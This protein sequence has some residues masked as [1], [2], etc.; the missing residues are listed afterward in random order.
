[1]LRRRGKIK[2]EY[3]HLANKVTKDMETLIHYLMYD[4]KL[5]PE[6]IIGTITS[7]TVLLVSQENTKKRMKTSKEDSGL[8]FRSG[9]EGRS[10]SDKSNSNK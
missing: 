4:Q 8:R 9:R 5:D 2:K 10:D 3:E 6:V 1:M 7:A